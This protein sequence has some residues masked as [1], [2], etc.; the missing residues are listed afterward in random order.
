MSSDAPERFMLG[1]NYWPAAQAMNWLRVYDPAITRRDFA[2]ARDAGFET[3]RVFLRWED[4]QPTED[5]FDA[6]CCDGSSTPPTQRW[7][8]VPVFSSRSS[9]AT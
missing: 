4:A 1:V 5:T 8:S 9:R 2:R 6:P 7:R 3:I